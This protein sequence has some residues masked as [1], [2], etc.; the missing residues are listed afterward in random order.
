MFYAPAVLRSLS[1]F[2]GFSLKFVPKEK[3]V[4]P[5]KSHAGIK[6]K[7]VPEKKSCQKKSR[8]GKKESC[9]KKS[10]AGKKKSCRKKKVVPEKKS[11]QKKR[12]VPEKKSRAGKKKSRAGKNG[13]ARK[14][15]SSEKGKSKS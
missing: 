1:S 12:V 11:C 2:P 7:V 10:R 14:L 9:R 3:R 8:A 13:R 5:E 4:A 6:T 15:K